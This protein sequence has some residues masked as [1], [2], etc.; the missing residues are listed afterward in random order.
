MR[1]CTCFAAPKMT[2]LGS[3]CSAYPRGR[4]DSFVLGSPAGLSGREQS[5][6]AS[7]G[8][9]QHPP[10]AAL[11]GR[12]ESS[13]PKGGSSLADMYERSV[14]TQ[15]FG[16]T[17]NLFTCHMKWQGPILGGTPY[18]LTELCH[19]PRKAAGGRAARPAS[20]PEGRRH[21]HSRY[22]SGH[23]KHIPPRG[24]GCAL[25]SL[26]SPS[27]CG[28]S[29][30]GAGA[31]GEGVGL[32]PVAGRTPALR[33]CAGASAAPPIPGRRPVVRAGLADG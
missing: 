21:C 27:S 10:P 2:R 32:R 33:R 30:L 3:R 13:S 23:A 28:F 26:P 31:G 18:S 25:A 14:D 5:S 1:L 11:R 15:L 20:L 9:P 6:A 16:A 29:R 24:R 8:C 22:V 17:A 4:F 7:T 19:L 12:S